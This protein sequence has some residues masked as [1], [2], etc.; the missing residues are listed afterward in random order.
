MT[1]SRRAINPRTPQTIEDMR[2]YLLEDRFVNLR[3]TR[4]GQSDFFVAEVGGGT[5]AFATRRLVDAIVHLGQANHLFL[6]GTFKV[7][8]RNPGGLV[9]LFTVHL[10]YMDVVSKILTFL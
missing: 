8:P 3:L 5:I 1:R 2:A 9:Q 6:D 10:L 7:V 4:D